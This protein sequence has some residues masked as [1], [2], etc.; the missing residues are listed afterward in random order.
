[1][2][3]KLVYSAISSA[4]FHMFT[5]DSFAYELLDGWFLLCVL[6]EVGDNTSKSIVIF[7]CT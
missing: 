3:N 6:I 4:D 2:I 1:M 7:L 5:Q